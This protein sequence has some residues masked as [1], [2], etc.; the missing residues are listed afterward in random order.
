MLLP[1]PRGALSEALF[2]AL[3]T[4]P[5]SPVDASVE[6]LC[7]EAGLDDATLA[8]WVLHE[9][10]YRGFDDVD[11]A[12]EW[13]LGALAVRRRLED[14]LEARMRERWAGADPRPD[15]GDLAADL[16]SYIENF[17]GPSLARFV[18]TAA[19]RD[20]VLELLR[21]RSI[22]HLKEA[23]PTAWVIPRLPVRAKA[24]LAELQYDEYGGGNPN[25]LHQNLF[26]RGMRAVGLNEKYGRYV[27]EAPTEFLEMNNALSMLGL[28]RR[29]RA[30][31]LGHL[32]AFETTSSEPSRRIAQG[33]RRLELAEELAEYY[34]EHVTA[35]AVHDQ[36]AVR[37]ICGTLVEDEPDQ[38]EEVF[39][40]AFVCM[41]MES[42]AAHAAFA[43]WGVSA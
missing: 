20:Q 17:Q 40:G 9:L 39:F 28:H 21:W 14:D 36:L 6:A 16:F 4:S 29:L 42:R 33:L 27:N 5:R 43:R 18:Q 30:A 13:D 8:L 35:D 26:T 15:T 19:T 11:D 10:S 22:Y 32:A 7:A 23:D 31:S 25:R 34:D 1:E 2:A 41:D 37:S 24:A 3:R 12:A 38:A